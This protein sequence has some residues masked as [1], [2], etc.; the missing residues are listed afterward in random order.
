MLLFIITLLTSTQLLAQSPGNDFLRSTG[1]IYVTVAVIALV[2]IGIIA[3]LAY[4]D[5]KLTNI[6]HQIKKDE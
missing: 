4:L 3:F 2:F 1:K 6:E 5:R